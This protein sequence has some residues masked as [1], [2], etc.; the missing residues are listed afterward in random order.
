MEA[1]LSSPIFVVFGLGGG[2]GSD[3]WIGLWGGLA[4]AVIGAAATA[5]ASYFLQKREFDR[6]EDVRRLDRLERQRTI[7]H[8]L[9][10]KLMGLQSNFVQMDKHLTGQFAKLKEGDE[11]WQ[12]VEPLF[13]GNDRILFEGDEEALLLDLGLND[14]FNLAGALPRIHNHAMAAMVSYSNKREELRSLVTHDDF[15]GRVGSFMMTRELHLKTAPLRQELNDLVNFLHANSARD[16]AES[17]EALAA[18]LRGLKSK[19]GLSIEYKLK[20]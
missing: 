18:T 13:V 1:W 10:I 9:L 14:E 8:R 6:Q 4:G 11:P 3:A 20:K 15:D 19:L 17:S 7:G 12:A 2:G 16:A 5:G